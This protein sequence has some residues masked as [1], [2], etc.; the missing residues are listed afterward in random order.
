MITKME[1]RKRN[2]KIQRRARRRKGSL[3]KRKTLYQISSGN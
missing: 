3:R 2:K 1:N